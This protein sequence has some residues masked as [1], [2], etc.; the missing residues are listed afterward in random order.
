MDG[1]L[2]VWN[3]DEPRTPII[4]YL[5]QHEIMLT[6]IFEIVKLF[7]QQRRILAQ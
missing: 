1:L 6:A 4:S 5:K 7:C 2:E 3:D